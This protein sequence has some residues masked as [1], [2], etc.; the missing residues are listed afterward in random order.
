MDPAGGAAA[1]VTGCAA[2]DLDRA[3]A[4][5][6]GNHRTVLITLRAD[7]RPQASPVVCGLLDD[8]R[9]GVSSRETAMKVRNLRRDPRV[10]LCVLN[11]G[12]FGDWIQVDGTAEVVPLPE[13]MDGLVALYRTVAGEHPDWD[14]YRTAM[15]EQ[16]RVLVRVAVERAGPDHSG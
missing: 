2:V 16:R 7:G 12:F 8:G 11:D 6:E 14:E 3:R 5:L 10:S 4:F 13:A 1:E 9:V 15:A